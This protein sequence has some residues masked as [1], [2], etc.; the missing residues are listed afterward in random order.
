[1]LGTPFLLT[2]QDIVV[3]RDERALFQLPAAAIPEARPD[4][5]YLFIRHDT[6]FTVRPDGMLIL[7]PDNPHLSDPPLILELLN[8]DPAK[9]PPHYRLV[10]ELRYSGNPPRPY[11]R[12]FAIER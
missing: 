7:D 5:K 11:A 1:V 9:L 4:V 3:N 2:R 12:V 8:A 6:Q 10:D